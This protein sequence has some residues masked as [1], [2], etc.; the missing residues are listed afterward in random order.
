LDFGLEDYFLLLRRVIY[1][2][3]GFRDFFKRSFAM[4]LAFALVITTVALGNM[5]EVKAAPAAPFGLVVSSPANNTIGVVWGRGEIDNYNVYIDGNRVASNVVC[6]YYEYKNIAAGTHTVG[7]TAVSGGTESAQTTE[8]VTVGGSSN[9]G[10]NTGSNSGST[11]TSQGGVIVYADANYSGKSATFGVGQ[12]NMADM[13]NKGIANDSISSIKVPLGYKV[14]FFADINFSGSSKVFSAD[15]SYVGNDWNDKVTSFIVEEAKYFIY[16]KHS[17]LVLDIVNAGRD[18]GTNLIQYTNNGGEWQQWKVIGVGNGYYKIA[19]AMHNKVIDVS[20]VSTQDGANVHIWEYVGG[21]TQHWKIDF[22]DGAYANI[23]SQNSGKALDGD[24]WSTTPGGNII[25]WAKGDKQANQL[26][27]FELANTAPA[28]GSGNNNNGSGTGSGT[29]ISNGEAIPQIPNLSARS[30][31]MYFKMN[32]KTN[33]KYPNNKV[34]WC[35]LGY[36]SNM[37]LCYVDKNG[38]LVR[39]NTGMNTISKNGRMC[40]NICY[41][42]ADA[43][44]LYMPDI[45]SGRMYMSYGEQVY[46][47]F[48]MA[49]D[50]RIGYAGPDLNNTTDPNQDVLFEFIEFTIKNKEYWGNTTRV[51]F[52]SFPVATRLIGTNGSTNGKYYAN[53]DR[54]VGDIGTRDSVFAAYKNE[55]PSEFKTLVTDKRIMAPCKLTFNEGAQYA[56]YY[57]NYINQFWSKYSSQDLVFTCEAGTFRGHVYGDYMRFTKDGDGGTYYVYKPTTQDVLEGKGNFNRGNSTELVIEA[58]LCAAFNR[59]VATQPENYANESAYYKNS[60]SNFYSGF[61]HNHAFD[62]YAYGFCY[63][64]VFDHSTL[65][66]FTNPTGLIIDLKW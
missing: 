40:A 59:G 31:R 35:I 62:G 26:W 32:N 8:S 56:H 52:Y 17:G 39:A 1:I 28:T 66:H 47:T 5:Q 48:N 43:D 61:F 25:Q 19:S 13:Q 30:D 14:T 10:S 7:V 3:K 24:A 53:Y 18:N 51:D 20:D 45:I 65:L 15:S 38:N 54:T 21:A 63:D 42:L 12:Y 64:D 36:D 55:V 11:N 50:G 49:A 23:I 22:V 9:T 34:Y 6:A 60:V 2:M 16:N 27:K 37:N 46:I 58:Q 41:S 29:I 57:D 4:L 44:Y 33:G